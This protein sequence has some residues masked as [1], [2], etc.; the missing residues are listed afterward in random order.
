[1]I[2]SPLAPPL[3]L[4]GRATLPVLISV[5]HAGREYPD[6]LVEHSRRGRASLEPLEDP[7][8]DR[9]VW[10]AL[11]LGVPAVVARAP[12]AAIDCNRGLHEIDPGT[13]AEVSAQEPGARS[14]AGLGL[15][16]SRTARHGELWRAPAGAAEMQRRVAEVYTP[17]HQS[18]ADGLNALVHRHG[19]AILLD[20]HS[21]PPRGRHQPAI[22]I[23]DR[24]GTSA[25]RFVS[26]AA[27]RIVRDAGFSVGFNDPYAGGWITQTHGRPALQRHAL[28][29]EVDRGLYL[30]SKLRSPGPNFD[31]VARL[32]ETLA[33]Q[34]GELL[35]QSALPAAAE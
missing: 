12:R 27:G 34:L 22:I 8:V 15:I 28:Q 9:L 25:A 18:I 35:A 13:A 31:R 7:L 2:R 30:D 4:P 1:M 16:P 21:M 3:L 19:T 17:F 10:R 20:C 5:A 26:A 33:A 29:I 32:F 14:R 11:S 23:G 6:W 24:H